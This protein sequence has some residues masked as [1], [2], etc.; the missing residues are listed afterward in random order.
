MKKIALILLLLAGGW[1]L[2]A[3]EPSGNGL[4][5]ASGFKSSF[6][7]IGNAPNENMAETGADIRIYSN[8]KTDRIC[9]KAESCIKSIYISDTNGRLVLVNKPM[10]AG[11]ITIPMSGLKSGVYLVRVNSQKGCMAYTFNKL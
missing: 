8:P 11:E 1:K 3:Q 10:V 6:L 7:I 9:I 4:V 2:S 5:A